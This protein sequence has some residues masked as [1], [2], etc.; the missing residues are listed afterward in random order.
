MGLIL[1]CGYSLKKK[2]IYHGSPTA[3]NL[4]PIRLDI[5]VDGQRFKDAFTWNPSGNFLSL[6]SILIIFM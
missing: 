6:F 3:E 2:K 1:S 4:V 5:E